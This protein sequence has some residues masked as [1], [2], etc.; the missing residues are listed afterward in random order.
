MTFLYATGCEHSVTFMYCQCEP[1]VATMVRARLWPA[2]P[3]C[4]HLVFSF[5]LLD[6]AEVLLL[7]CQVALNRGVGRPKLLGGLLS[8]LCETAY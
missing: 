7:E 3:Q 1:L 8:N 6:W 4:P 5:E 2:T